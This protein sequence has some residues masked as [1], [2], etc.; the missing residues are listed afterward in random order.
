[1]RADRT[2]AQ[3]ANGNSTN[4]PG[5]F[6]EQGANGKPKYTSTS[7]TNTNLPPSPPNLLVTHTSPPPPQT[8]I[9]DEPLFSNRPEPSRL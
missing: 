6:G 3:G 9:G 8:L 7:P 4:K 1:M 5:E 2:G